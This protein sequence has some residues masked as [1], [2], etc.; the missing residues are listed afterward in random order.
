MDD[1]EDLV[2]PGRFDDLFRRANDDDAGCNGVLR[3]SMSKSQR[4]TKGGKNDD[5]VQRNVLGEIEKRLGEAAE[6][7]RSASEF[8]QTVFE[9]LACF[10]QD[11]ENVQGTVR[12]DVAKT[13]LLACQEVCRPLSRLLTSRDVTVRAELLHARNA[14]RQLCALCTQWVVQAQCLAVGQGQKKTTRKR[15]KGNNQEAVEHWS[16]DPLR[17]RVLDALGDMLRDP[18]VKKLWNNGLVDS[19]LKNFLCTAVGRVIEVSDPSG[20]LKEREDADAVNVN[21]TTTRFLKILPKEVFH[22]LM[23]VWAVTVFRLNSGLG[24]DEQISERRLAVDT[25]CMSVLRVG[26]VAG[27]VLP[28]VIDAAAAEFDTADK[29]NAALQFDQQTTSSSAAAALVEA[30][31]CVLTEEKFET[32][33]AVMRESG[34]SVKHRRCGEAVR[35]FLEK[36]AESHETAALLVMHGHVR[37]LQQLLDA[38]NHMARVGALECFAQL[39]RHLCFVIKQ[40]RRSQLSS[41]EREQM[42]RQ[43]QLSGG[44]EPQI[45]DTAD[46][47]R[48]IDSNVSDVEDF[49]VNYMMPRSLDSH[50]LVRAKLLAMF[51]D[52]AGKHMMHP[53]GPT[54]LSVYLSISTVCCGRL[55]DSSANVRARALTLLLALLE[56][57][58]FGPSMRLDEVDS[59]LSRLREAFGHLVRM[60]QRRRYR[61]DRAAVGAVL[62]QESDPDK[63]DDSDMPEQQVAYNEELKRI[64]TPE[65]HK[66]AVELRKRIQNVQ[67]HSKFAHCMDDA[68][69]NSVRWL[70]LSPSIGDATGAVKVFCGAKQ[71]QLSAADHGLRHSLALVF[72]AEAPKVQQAVLDA[73][74]A[75]FLSDEI[76]P[77]DEDM[78]NVRAQDRAVLNTDKLKAKRLLQFARVPT[79]ADLACV[80]EILGKLVQQGK[81]NSGSVQ[82]LFAVC[83]HDDVPIQERRR[84]ARVLNFIIKA[85]VTLPKDL[86]KEIAER[87]QD[88]RRVIAQSVLPV[89]KVLLQLSD[90]DNEENDAAGNLDVDVVLLRECLS[91]MQHAPPRVCDQWIKLAEAGTDQLSRHA[92]L[93]DPEQLVVPSLELAESPAAM[94]GLLRGVFC[95]VRAL[96]LSDRVSVAQWPALA[97][98]ALQVAFEAHPSPLRFGEAVLRGLL[99]SVTRSV[100]DDYM[101]DGDSL[102]GSVAGMIDFPPVA[103]DDHSDGHS[104]HGDGEDGHTDDHSDGDDDQKDGLAVKLPELLFFG[105]ELAIRLVVHAEGLET[106]LKAQVDTSKTAT[107]ASQENDGDDELQAAAGNTASGTLFALEQ[108]RESAEQALLDTSGAAASLLAQMGRLVAY[109]AQRPTLTGAHQTVFNTATVA[110]ARFMCVSR[111]YCEEH[112]QLLFT[113]LCGTGSHRH[114]SLAAKRESKH[115]PKLEPSL[116]SNHEPKHEPMSTQQMVDEIDL[117]TDADSANTAEASQLADFAPATELAVQLLIALGDI[118]FRFPNLFEPYSRRL[119]EQ[120]HS[121]KLRVRQHAL[122]VLSHLLLNDMLKVKDSVAEIALLLCDESPHV[123]AHVRDF[124]NRLAAKS[125]ARNTVYNVVPDTISRLSGRPDVTRDMFET[126][127]GFLL[128]FV[129]KE[130]NVD[131]LVDKLCH[132]FKSAIGD[133]AQARNL[134]YCLAKLEYGEKSVGTLIARLP[135]YKMHLGDDKVLE[136]FRQLRERLFQRTFVDAEKHAEVRQDLEKWL[137]RCEEEHAEL[138]KA[139]SGHGT[140]HALLRQNAQ[141]EAEEKM[142]DDDDD[143]SDGE[144][145]S[146]SSHSDSDQE[147]GDGDKEV[148]DGADDGADDPPVTGSDADADLVKV[149]VEPSED[150]ESSEEGE[151]G[152]D[153]S[154]EEEATS[155]SSDDASATGDDSDAD[156]DYD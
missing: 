99:R 94:R 110:L 141:A 25:L 21:A 88:I 1:V 149:T 107:T 78:D 137:K 71:F 155:A 120:L 116:K 142:R 85:V 39:V 59:K 45:I 56:N 70:L 124:F 118:A 148:A 33:R 18:S 58:P 105:G 64:A 46:T 92:A 22:S 125:R 156:S 145:S 106:L 34:R 35:A 82:V 80:E 40:Q 86:D 95:T 122:V 8:T 74:A 134:A 152:H 3:V 114:D 126:V 75:L 119:Y 43:R 136:H 28:Q 32:C 131:S 154:E 151:S 10:V 128:H 93:G 54:K 72:R 123:R 7:E 12:N 101:D 52:L 102:M 48:S 73:V 113:V 5:A 57:N 97:Q 96:L 108:L 77:V 144:D 37:A 129:K 132:R 23:R 44:D 2:L 29:E 41:T 87:I 15:R 109:L 121:K 47:T 53:L 84:A 13:L 11:M 90:F 139:E 49:L 27:E 127:L 81:L 62:Q 140:A 14:V 20:E 133:E 91:W 130:R 42:R 36:F 143:S 111:Q 50:S 31:V 4:P 104:D 79:I 66:K 150:A 146:D 100:D 16:A 112:L 135:V 55:R 147:E 115:E 68:L 30:F 138:R 117:D 83:T 153:D 26:R 6:Q 65:E 103:V 19:D 24:D 67:A 98:V 17:L 89:L 51:E 38:V 69:R 61:A 76:R 63:V 9:P 60:L